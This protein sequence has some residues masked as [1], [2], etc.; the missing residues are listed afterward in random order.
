MSATTSSQ[1]S[2]ATRIIHYRYDGL[3]RLIEAVET[4]GT[5]YSYTYDLVGNRTAAWQNGALV[6]SWTY[7]AA[8]QVLGWSYDAA[9]NLLSD[10][11]ASYRYDALGRLTH[12]TSGGTT[13][14][15]TSNG[16]GVLVAAERGTGITH[17]TQDLAAPLSQVLHQTQGTT[18]TTV[19]S[20]H[21]RL[22]AVQHG[23]RSW[24]LHDG[25]GS[26][27]LLLDEAGGYSTAWAM[28]RGGCRWPAARLR[29]ASR[30]SCRMQA[31]G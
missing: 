7:N 4:P 12:V 28:T 2:H 11:T 14:T 15:A 25:L 21:A 27:R 30:A 8:D 22:A 26:V 29:S 13:T 24:E 9:G 1:P 17:F 31:W 10:N 5:V 19:L 20:G 16:N 23:T 3:Q 6:G 18:T